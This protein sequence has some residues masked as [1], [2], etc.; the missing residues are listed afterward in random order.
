MAVLRQ[1][2]SYVPILAVLH[3]SLGATLAI[4]AAT[5]NT[6]S[7]QPDITKS[8]LDCSSSL[9]VPILQFVITNYIAHAFTI[10]FSPGY[11][12]YY[13]LIFSLKALIFPC[14]GLLTACRTVELLAVTEDDPLT[15]ALEA[16]ALCTVARTKKWKPE[17]G[18]EVWLPKDL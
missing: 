15:R 18:D 16:G 9:I 4:R 7:T 10:R 5:N 3:G 17:E 8:F 11:A 6:T 14:F 2:G 1:L 12:K 13:T